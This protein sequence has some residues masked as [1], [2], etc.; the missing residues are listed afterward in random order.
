MLCDCISK[1]DLNILRSHLRVYRDVNKLPLFIFPC[2]GDQSLHS[3]RRFFRAYVSSN[4]TEALKNVFCLTAEDVAAEMDGSRLNLLQQE[5][6]LA[7]ISDW[8]L[9]LQRAVDLFASWAL[10]PLCLMLLGSLLLLLESNIRA[11]GAS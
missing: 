11:L 7:D 4:H 2:G 8:I 9:I 6:M 5:A 1:T 3:S 10:S